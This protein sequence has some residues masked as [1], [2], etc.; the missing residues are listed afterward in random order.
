MPYYF[1]LEKD[2]WEICKAFFLAG[3]NRNFT[4][5]KAKLALYIVIGTIITVFM[6]LPLNDFAEQLVFHPAFVGGLLIITGGTLFLSEYLSSK[7]I[8]N[9][10]VFLLNKLY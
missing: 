7:K 1:I 8:I 6:A 10:K 3:K 5:H 2:I 4:D 9:L